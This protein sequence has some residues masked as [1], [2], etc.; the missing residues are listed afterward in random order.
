MMDQK[1]LNHL[2]IIYIENKIAADS[3]IEDMQLK[4]RKVLLS[5]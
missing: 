5:R 2:A 3:N 4:V 1:R